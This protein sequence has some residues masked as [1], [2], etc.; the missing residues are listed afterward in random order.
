MPFIGDLMEPTYDI[1]VYYHISGIIND[2]TG[3]A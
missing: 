1:L 3:L 2:Y